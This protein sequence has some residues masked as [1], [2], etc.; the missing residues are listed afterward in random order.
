MLPPQR[1]FLSLGA[2]VC[3]GCSCRRSEPIN[4]SLRKPANTERL[5]HR[6]PFSP[7]FK[8]LS[9]RNNPS[10]QSLFSFLLSLTSLPPTLP[11]RSRSRLLRTE[12]TK[13]LVHNMADHDYQAV[14]A[15]ARTSP[16]GSGDPYYSKSSGYIASGAAPA[17]S[18]KRN[19]LK[20]G[21]PIAVIVIVGAV[22]G[23]VLGSRSS[24]KNDTSTGG[25]NSNSNNNGNNPNGGPKNGLNRLPTSTD[26]FYG[27]PIYPSSVSLF[28][29][30]SLS[31]F[32]SLPKFLIGQLTLS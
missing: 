17:K 5:Q 29:S 6:R 9:Q 23:G 4:G 21:I 20:F 18:S 32:T 13:R 1:G 25:N 8:R 2:N 15:P 24:K 22:V 14:N 7:V 30:I 12:D 27:M 16:Y 28:P 10:L 3:S 26:P 31:L 11:G 19:W